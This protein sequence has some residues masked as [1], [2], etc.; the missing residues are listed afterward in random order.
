MKVGLVTTKP[1]ATNPNGKLYMMLGLNLRTGSIFNIIV[2]NVCVSGTPGENVLVKGEP[3]TI[4]RVEY[5][6]G[7]T[8]YFFT[9]GSS[10][11]EIELIVNKINPKEG[12]VYF[13]EE[14]KGYAK[15][16]KPFRKG[17]DL[18]KKAIESKSCTQEQLKKI[19]VQAFLETKSM[20]FVGEFDRVVF[21]DGSTVSLYSIMSKRSR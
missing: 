18:V 17:A 10:S 2:S 8:T 16:I 4:Q 14:S 6:D 7:K 21:E 15:I 3:K 19:R 5:V 9:D 20:S 1:S 13:F 12:Q 11:N